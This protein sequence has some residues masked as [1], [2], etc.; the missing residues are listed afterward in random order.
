MPIKKTTGVGLSR[1]KVF[2]VTAEACKRVKL[3]KYQC[4]V[5]SMRRM[6]SM[7]RQALIYCF[8]IMLTGCGGLELIAGS[9]A[10]GL[11]GYTVVDTVTPDDDSN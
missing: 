5:V 3:I 11:A 8:F 9:Y 4:S 10:V 6:Y 1:L 7:M 2:V